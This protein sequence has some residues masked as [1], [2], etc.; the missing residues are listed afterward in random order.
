MRQLFASGG[1]SIG[2]S[3]SVLEGANSKSWV[4]AGGAPPWGSSEADGVG[5]ECWSPWPLSSPHLP[6]LHFMPLSSAHTHPPAGES[7]SFEMPFAFSL[8]SIE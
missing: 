4:G 7:S 2:D 8:I 1:Q 6:W 3:A 5:S